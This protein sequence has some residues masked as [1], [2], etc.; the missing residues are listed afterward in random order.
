MSSQM[1]RSSFLGLAAALALSAGAVA[2]G[3]SYD[4]TELTGTVTGSL[5]GAEINFQHVTV[6]E[7]TLLKVHLVSLDSS[8]KPMD[9]QL[10]TDDPSVMQTVQVQSDRDYAFLGLKVGQTKVTIKANENTV[11]ILDAIVTPQPAP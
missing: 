5:Q 1:I 11:L 10:S 3:P 4:H 2:C 6:P 8:N 9:N 7:G